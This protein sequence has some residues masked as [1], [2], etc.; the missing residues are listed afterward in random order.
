[1]KI[2]Y[3]EYLQKQK[4][5]TTFEMYKTSSLKIKNILSALI[6]QLVNS[7]ELFKPSML[8]MDA[9]TGLVVPSIGGMSRKTS[10]S[11]IVRA[12]KSYFSGVLHKR[13]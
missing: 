7:T 5:K 4:V 10:G 8:F 12:L 9:K 6:Y 3:P 11:L 1:M 2:N 13:N